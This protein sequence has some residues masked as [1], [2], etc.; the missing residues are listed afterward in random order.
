MPRLFTGLEIPQPVGNYLGALRGG[1]PGA[2]FIEPSD[3]HITLR[4]IGDVDIRTANEIADRLE[5]VK[6]KAFHL[7]LSE[8]R[9]FG[10]DAPHSVVATLHHAP[11]LMELQAE[12]ERMMQRLGLPSEARKYTPHITIARLKNSGVRDVGEWIVTRSPLSSAPFQVSRF[13]L[14]S[15]RASTGGG[16]YIVEGAYPLQK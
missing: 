15:S 2:R 6:R 13:V 8:L 16:P 11:E 5:A 1:I 4:F 14:Y 10:R 9:S 7:R 12:Q 3:Y